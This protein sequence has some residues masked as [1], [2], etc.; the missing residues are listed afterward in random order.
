MSKRLRL[1]SRLSTRTAQRLRLAAGVF[2]LT[3]LGAGVWFLYTFIAQVSDARAQKAQEE[4]TPGRAI[5][6]GFSGRSKISLNH[7]LLPNGVD[8]CNPI[9]ISVRHDDL[10]LNTFGG[11]VTDRDGADMLMTASNGESL[12][13]FSI[14]RY[15]PMVGKLLAWVY[16]DSTLQKQ[17][18]CLYLYY[19]NEQAAAVKQEPKS[20]KT[21]AG[22]WKFNGNFQVLGSTP[23]TGEYKGIKDDE[24]RFAGAK[25]FLAVESGAAV[26]EPGEAFNF[27][28][29]ITLSAW[30]KTRGS[31]QNQTI[32]CN[33]STQGGCRLYL[34][35]DGRLA[36]EIIGANGRLASNADDKKGIVLEK[37][38]W[39]QVTA[40][41]SSAT[42]TIQTYVNGKPDRSASSAVAYAKGSWLVIGADADA[43]SGFFN[44]LIDEL[45]VSPLCLN[46]TQ[47]QSSWNIENEPEN[48]ISMDGQEVFSA[49]PSLATIS[50]FEAKVNGSHVAVNWSTTHEYNLDYFTLERSS[51]GKQFTKVAN[52]FAEGNS[53]GA[54]NYMIQ[55]PAP[56]FGNA[57]YRLRFTSFRKE[58]SVSN[59]VSVSYD[60]PPSVLNIRKVEPNPFSDNFEVVY[61]SQSPEKMELK[62]TSISGKVV[63]SQSLTPESGTDNHFQFK[64]QNSLLPGI[65]FLSLSQADEQKTIK[66]IKRM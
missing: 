5:L 60:A 52:Q 40:T 59:I 3:A 4:K 53:D 42:K 47:I 18:P 22:I 11:K 31:D 27:A 38:K 2:T 56:I 62:L 6:D 16:P 9:L 10:R 58:S 36:F 29:D 1:K 48:L 12:L 24:G 51:D 49:S 25:D 44:G 21:F 39:V 54:R 45:R 19:G 32:F 55:D 20:S 23:I 57:Y 17:E 61:G 28:N 65:Y 63:Y 26:F 7:Q 30:I 8:P 46:P 37:D 14:E 15:D 50:H 41:Y 64:D 66:L 13:N 43:K 34:Q 33:E 35:K